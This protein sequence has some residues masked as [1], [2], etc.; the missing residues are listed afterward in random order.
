N[1]KRAFGVV[2]VFKP[3]REQDY[4]RHFEERQFRGEFQFRKP[5]LS[6]TYYLYHFD[7][8]VRLLISL[9]TGSRQKYF[10]DFYLI[11]K[12][13]RQRP[14]IHRK[15]LDLAQFRSLVMQ[16]FLIVGQ[17]NLALCTAVDLMPKALPESVPRWTVLRLLGIEALF[18]GDA[19]KLSDIHAVEMGEKPNQ[20]L[21]DR[22]YR[23]NLV[24]QSIFAYYKQL[25]GIQITDLELVRLIRVAENR[26][27]LGDLMDLVPTI[28]RRFVQGPAELN[29]SDRV[30][31]M[32]EAKATEWQAS[33][34][35]IAMR[36]ALAFGRMGHTQQMTKFLYTLADMPP[37]AVG[38][39]GGGNSQR[40][41]RALIALLESGE[42][43]DGVVM[44]ALEHLGKT[45]I[46]PSRTPLTRPQFKAMLVEEIAGRLCAGQ[47]AS[48]HATT[49]LLGAITGRLSAFATMAMVNRLYQTSPV[50]GVS[51]V[52]THF[53]AL[54]AAAQQESL[55]FVV[56]A[57]QRRPALLR[58]V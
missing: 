43:A 31:L 20:P 30:A 16:Y 25:T 45:D 18:A 47:L 24:A 56:R 33:A 34:V 32:H 35:Q 41:G 28:V 2:N 3:F 46:E 9:P 4:G 39:S 51:W 1:R 21:S 17:P 12:A 23:Y 10:N 42:D 13:L 52:A 36:Y 5:A 6:Y 53:Y 8:Y 49:A 22:E 58:Q 48:G 38:G 29:G 37:R 44:T 14:H 7:L 50:L 15:I 11:I 19:E 55:A 26:G 40:L 54:D 27:L 57:F